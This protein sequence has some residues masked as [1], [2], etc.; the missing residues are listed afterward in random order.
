[1]AFDVVVHVIG[2]HHVATL[3]RVATCPLMLHNGLIRGASWCDV[4][5]YER[6]FN[7]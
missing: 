4:I 2:L 7:M 3:K 6:H 1:M 5:R